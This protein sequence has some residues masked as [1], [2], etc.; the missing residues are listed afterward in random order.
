MKKCSECDVEMLD[1]RLYGKPRRMDMD[2][3]INKFYVDV[4]TGQ[5][6]SF[7]GFEMEATR[8]ARLMAKVCPICG[9]VELYIDT[10]EIE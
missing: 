8:K 10:T 4:Q 5:S 9:K 7:L 1:G 6:T 2:H 3:D